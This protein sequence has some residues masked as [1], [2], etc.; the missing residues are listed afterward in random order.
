MTF[1]DLHGLRHT[2]ELEAET[3]YEAAVLALQ[4]FRKS[5]FVEL[6]PGLAS[7]LEVSVREAVITHQVSLVR[8]REWTERGSTNPAETLRRRRLKEILEGCLPKPT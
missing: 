6:P 2:V 4:A 3:V 8:L 7:K 1:T 5:V